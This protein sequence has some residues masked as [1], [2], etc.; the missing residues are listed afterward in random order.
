MLE[1]HNFKFK[2]GSKKKKED[3]FG[4]N[5]ADWEVYKEIVRIKL[6]L[7]PQ[8]ILLWY[9]KGKKKEIITYYYYQQWQ[10][11]VHLALQHPENADSDSEAEEDKLE[12]LETLLK[13]HDPEFQR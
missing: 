3:T 9:F 6:N 12:E 11:Y 13:E 8:S 7:Q 10:N 4:Q 2:G 5:D 1:E